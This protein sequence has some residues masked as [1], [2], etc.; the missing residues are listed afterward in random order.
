MRATV[1]AGL[2]QQGEVATQS[3]NGGREIDDLGHSRGEPAAEVFESLHSRVTLAEGPTTVGE[4]AV[5]LVP[6][7]CSFP[8]EA[9]ESRTPG[10]RPSE[11]NRESTNWANANWVKSEL[12][13]KRNGE[14]NNPV[15][16]NKAP[17]W[18]PRGLGRGPLCAGGIRGCE[19]R[20]RLR[21]TWCGLGECGAHWAT[22]SW[23]HSRR[24]RRWRSRGECPGGR[25]GLPRE[26]PARGVSKDCLGPA[27]G[28][29]PTVSCWGESAPTCARSIHLSRRNC[30]RKRYAIELDTH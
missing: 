15:S 25:C 26:P 28:S 12:G 2:T 8:P 20:R 7:Q 22:T 1:R 14:R 10:R 30:K 21:A 5:R 17:S 3:G 9:S 13:K 18:C 16:D 6:A 29:A 11:A 27:G 24:L 19:E 23:V 4:G